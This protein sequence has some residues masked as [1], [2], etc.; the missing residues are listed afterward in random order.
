M[1]D[2]SYGETPERVGFMLIPQ[3]S[4]MAFFS[5][6]EPLRV[7]NR[8][9]GRALYE[10]RLISTDG[11]PV[12]ASCGVVLHPDGNLDTAQDCQTV[13]VCSGV[14]VHR[15]GDKTLLSWLR[16]AGRR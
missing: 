6:V 13:V 1:H 14:E 5:A 16:R 15:C 4:M 7:A 3:F 8:E 9:S 12:T 10:W 2:W 11:G